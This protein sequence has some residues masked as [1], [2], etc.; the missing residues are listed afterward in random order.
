MVVVVVVGG[1]GQLFGGIET[2]AMSRGNMGYDGINWVCRPGRQGGSFI[3][4]CLK[5]RASPE[6]SPL[7]HTLLLQARKGPP[8]TPNRRT[9]GTTGVIHVYPLA[10]TLSTH[11]HTRTHKVDLPR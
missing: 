11:T 1:A 2:E 4:S 9:S 3:I 7:I 6:V 8:E 5:Q 10:H